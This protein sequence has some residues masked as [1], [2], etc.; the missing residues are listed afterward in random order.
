MYVR[1][2]LVIA[3]AL[4]GS[5]D[6]VGDGIRPV[7]S[8]EDS[9]CVSMGYVLADEDTGAP[10]RDDEWH[11]FRACQ[12]TT[13]CGCLLNEQRHGKWRFHVDQSGVN[14]QQDGLPNLDIP[15]ELYCLPE[16]HTIECSYRNGKLC[17]GYTFHDLN[18]RLLISGEF[19]NG[20]QGGLMSI[21]GCSK[22]SLGTFT[23]HGD[24]VRE[25]DDLDDTLVTIFAQGQFKNGLRDGVWVRWHSGRVV[26]SISYVSGQK[27]GLETEY[28]IDGQK[29]REGHWSLDRQIGV[30]TSWNK[31]LTRMETWRDGLRHGAWLTTS[32]SGT[33][34]GSGYYR[35]GRRDG[36]ETFY[37]KSG[38]KKAEGHW[39]DGRQDGPRTSWYPTGIKECCSHWVNGVES[40]EW[41]YFDICGNLL[42]SKAWAESALLFA[43]MNLGI[44]RTEFVGLRKPRVAI[45]KFVNVSRDGE[46]MGL[47]GPSISGVVSFWEILGS[48]NNPLSRIDPEPGRSLQLDQSRVRPL[49]SSSFLKESTVDRP[50]PN[51]GSVATKPHGEHGKYGEHDKHGA[52][53]PVGETW[54]LRLVPLNRLLP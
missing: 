3:I 37:Y 22:R 6:P 25:C 23:D 5:C 30:W 41:L 36:V 48:V 15:E 50:N 54:A 20:R 28:G 26:S 29:I 44:G 2:S 40:G 24:G 34:L 1:L 9:E 7:R 43:G 46:I 42:T 19:K 4:L 32:S 14:L 52:L 11:Y 45:P 16:S 31:V 51:K 21:Y 35:E 18:G 53:G 10:V 47:I 17:G 39:R 38:Q 33:L 13:S 27:H 8:H 12:S 49:V